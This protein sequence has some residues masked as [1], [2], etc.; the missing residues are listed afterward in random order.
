MRAEFLSALVARFEGLEDQLNTLDAATGDGDHGTTI[1]K[2]LR[3]AM[4]APDTSVKAFR[5]AAG[6][7]SGS[8]FA[9]IL[10][11]LEAADDGAPLSEAL[12]KA[13]ERIAQLGQ[14]KVGDKTM[15]DALIPAASKATAGEAAQA[16]AAG[17]DTT[18]DMAAKRGRAKYVEGAG[19]GHLDAGAT[20]VAE[21][22]DEYAKFAEGAR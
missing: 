4:D 2:G 22:L 11:A 20:T 10:A 9:T 6:G 17:R 15:L 12:G 7:A 3:A 21:I 8:L 13:A 19:V 5:R 1:L 18:R 16:A 14:A